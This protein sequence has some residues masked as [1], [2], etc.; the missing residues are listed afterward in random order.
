MTMGQWVEM[1]QAIVDRREFMV[2]YHLQVHGR[3]NHIIESLGGSP[4][5]VAY[6][7]M[8]RDAKP[9]EYTAGTARTYKAD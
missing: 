2:G 1:L 5:A 9:P 3:L 6:F 8:V 4:H 7:Q